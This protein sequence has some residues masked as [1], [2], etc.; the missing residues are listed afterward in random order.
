MP[1]RIPPPAKAVTSDLLIEQLASRL[2][3]VGRRTPLRDAAVLAAI[4]AVELA[5]FLLMGGMRHDMHQALDQ[6]SWWWKLGSM[7]AIATAGMGS[8]IISLDPSRSPRPGLRATVLI[9]LACVALGWLLDS[10]RYGLGPLV[11]RLNWRQGIGCVWKMS[12]LAIPTAIALG[13]LLN[14]GAP[15]DRGGTA[16]AAGI[17][18]AACGAFV[19]VFACPSDDP[20]YIAVWYSV[21]LGLVSSSSQTILRMI[22]RW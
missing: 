8:A 5:L 15:V 1:S 9:L 13:V 11:E 22:A 2:H 6:P 18:A 3:P 20:L 17:G 7:V 21:G 10:A 16:W 4:V 14:R 12:V 19:F